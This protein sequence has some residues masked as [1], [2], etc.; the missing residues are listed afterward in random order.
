MFKILRNR[1]IFIET[2]PFEE[3]EIADPLIPIEVVT[4]KRKKCVAKPRPS[5]S[6]VR[7]EGP[8]H[9]HPCRVLNC[10]QEEKRELRSVGSQTHPVGYYAESSMQVE[11]M[12]QDELVESTLPSAAPELQWPKIKREIPEASPEPLQMASDATSMATSL[13]FG[14]GDG[15]GDSQLPEKSTAP[16]RNSNRLEKAAASRQCHPSC[17]HMGGNGK[18]V[19]LSSVKIHIRGLP[20]SVKREQLSELFG[21]FGELTAVEYPTNRHPRNPMGRGYA[22]VQFVCPNACALAIERMNGGTIGGQ[23]IQVAPFQ[24]RMLRQALPM[25][26]YSRRTRSRSRSP[27]RSHR[28]RSRSPRRSHRSRSRSPRRS[29]R[30]RSRS[31]RRS[32]RT[33]SRSPRRSARIR[34]Q[35]IRRQPDDRTPKAQ[36]SPTPRPS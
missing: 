31:P 33:R 1:T 22:F 15:G 17:V 16:L 30:S 27:R 2:G 19:P 11:P 12:E 23:R 20:L 10:L 7:H 35:T 6:S 28:S 3:E 8:L 32:H 4:N 24:A 14:G 26:S 13:S 36:L 5:G 21:H 34:A 29:H 18:R 25:R 9:Y